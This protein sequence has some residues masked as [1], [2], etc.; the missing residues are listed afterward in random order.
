MAVFDTEDNGRTEY[1]KQTLESLA[2]TV[3][4]NKHRLVVIDNGSCDKTVNAIYKSEVGMFCDIIHNAENLGTAK[5]I[6][7]GI[8]LRKP[9]EHVVKL[10]ND[11]T[12][13]YVE[14]L[15]ELEEAADRDER[16]GIV[17]LKRKDLCETPYHTEENFRSKLF[18]LP[19]EP[20]QRWI[21]AE[22]VAHV[23]GTCTL[24]TSR[25][26]DKVGYMT[27]LTKYGLDDFNI[28]ARSILSGFINCFLTH[29]EIEHLDNGG[30]E[31]TQWK[32]EEAAKKW[33]ESCA[34]VDA[35]KNGSEPIYYNGGYND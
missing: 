2:K 12:T 27:Q 5:A 34:L 7:Q 21:Y 23:M 19:H 22:S 33:T 20:G 26:L 11:C 35:Y 10:D 24:L 3:D 25:L 17:A 31:Y 13:K 32:I 8:R 9:G 18:M 30:T 14:W 6:N 29:I 28:S 4:W 16:I 15:D 1:T